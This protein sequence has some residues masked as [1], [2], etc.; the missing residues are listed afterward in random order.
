VKLELRLIDKSDAEKWLK[1]DGWLVFAYERGGFESYL[2]TKYF[3][4]GTPKNAEFEAL[5]VHFKTLDGP[6]IGFFVRIKDTE[7][8]RR[9]LK[10][11]LEEYY[12]GKVS[13][14]K[15]NQ[16]LQSLQSE[17]REIAKFLR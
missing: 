5:V 16:T 15:F 8:N 14:K 13:W 11:A 2:E 4:P 7:V 3:T 17:I 1:E 9:A 10:K 12:M 6:K